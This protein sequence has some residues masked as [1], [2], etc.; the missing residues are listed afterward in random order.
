MAV[1]PL[2][3]AASAAPPAA[4]VEIA[5]GDENA[6]GEAD[7]GTATPRSFSADSGLVCSQ[8]STRNPT[9]D[10]KQEPLLAGQSSET[11]DL[12]NAAKDDGDDDGDDRLAATGKMTA[13]LDPSTC[14][15]QGVDQGASR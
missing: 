1:L 12:D 6:E 2:A 4:S 13:A 5:D 8:G 10:I 11:G 14:L 9:P 3:A 7:N 15:G